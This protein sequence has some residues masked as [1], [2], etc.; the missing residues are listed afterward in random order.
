MADQTFGFMDGSQYNSSG[1][2][3]SGATGTS[4]V[5]PTVPLNQPVPQ[6]GVTTPVTVTPTTQVPSTALTTPKTGLDI[7][8]LLQQNV[9]KQ[10][11]LI[12]N[13]TGYLTPSEQ[14]LADQK[15]LNDAINA[16]QNFDVSYEG[17][18]QKIAKQPIALEFQ[19]GQQAALTRD[20]A[21]TRS[22]LARQVDAYTRVLQSTQANRQQKL[23]A[24][25]FL[26][27]AN[28]NSLSDTITL[29][30]ATAPEN[31]GNVVDPQT[32]EM[33]VIMKNPITGE[34]TKNNLGVV[35]TPQRALDNVKMAQDAGVTAPFYSRD[36]KTVIN[37][38]N[39]REYS[40][41]EQ[42]AADGVD[43]KGWS[44]VQWGVKSL[45]QQQLDLQKQ[46]LDQSKYQLG[47]VRGVDQYGQPIETSV[48]F[49]TKTG[50]TSPVGT[51]PQGSADFTQAI[52]DYCPPGT[53]GGQCA[54]YAENVADFGTPGNL[55]G[56]DLKAKQATVN[57]YG[58]KA[59][60]WRAQGAQIGDGIIFNIGQYGHVSVVT[61]VN[62][63][64]TVTVTDSNYSNDGKVQNR[65]VNIGDKSIYGVVRGTL[66]NIQQNP[67]ANPSSQDNIA[68]QLPPDIRSAYK[69]LNG[70]GFI[71]MGLL[72]GE[73]ANARARAIAGTLGIPIL[74][75]QSADKIT[76]TVVTSE[77]AKDLVK[78]ILGYANKLQFA[79]DRIGK[80]G[81]NA[82]QWG[83]KITGNENIKIYEDKRDSLLSILSRAS[84]E[85]GVLTD[86]DIARIRTGLPT[87]YDTK[88]VAAAKIAGFNDLFNNIVQGSIDTYLPTS[89]QPSNTNYTSILDSILKGQQ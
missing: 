14:E 70:R 20:A 18:L 78:Q 35:Q 29:M 11:S 38:Q 64:G 42:A 65:T 74:D 36:G 4:V 31:I 81:Q 84:G 16:Q 19:Q 69:T 61:A 87:I 71:N 43:T 51:T 12:Q 41:I 79:S 75:K 17:G 25:K 24:A 46:Q 27:D 76:T 49:N 7:A 47:T 85:K 8:S 63:D 5:P 13:I 33:T 9:A 72:T 6:T 45:G 15:R 3:V 44:N 73:T 40:S 54:V 89:S 48:V 57:K 10:D 80:F 53:K 62:G 28:R 52:N 59:N 37:T 88:K 1:Q 26:Y 82:L 58:L 32:G 30:K 67:Q 77:Q 83:S 66:K 39:G 60:D 2:Q 50:Q 68:Q 56:V 34:V 21:F 22:S 55:L 86:G 23:E